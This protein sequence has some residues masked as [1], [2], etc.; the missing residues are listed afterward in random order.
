MSSEKFLRHIVLLQFKDG[1][2]RE[3]IKEVGQAFLALLTQIEAIHD[4][5][6][7][8]VVNEPNPCQGGESKQSAN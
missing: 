5:E 3:Q 7:G 4:L 8:V 6:W 1:V 2:N